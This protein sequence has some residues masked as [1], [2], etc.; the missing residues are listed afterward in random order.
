MSGATS[1]TSVPIVDISGRRSQDR[2]ECER[3]AGEIGNTLFER[4][5]ASTK[6]LFALP[7]E[8][9]MRSYI[10]LSQCHRGY[11]RSARRASNPELPICRR[12]STPRWI[13]PPTTP[14]I[15]R[16]SRCSAPTRGRTCRAAPMW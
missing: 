9:K 4:V 8:E 15:L 5:L 11:V 13:C 3:V 1:F 10:G 7:L 16:E 12:H 6:E 14:T 2:A